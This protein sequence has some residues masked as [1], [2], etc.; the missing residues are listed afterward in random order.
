MISHHSKKYKHFYFNELETTTVE[1]IEDAIAGKYNYNVFK[2]EWITRE[3]FEQR[4]DKCAYT[5]IIWSFA[6]MQKG[7]LFAK[8]IED[9]KRSLHN[10]VVYNEWDDNAVKFLEIRKWPDHLS[11]RGRRLMS[12]SIIVRK[13][14]GQFGNRQLEQ[15]ERLE[16]LQR[17][18]R[19]E[20]LEQLQRLEQ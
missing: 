18:E 8:E 5:R 15:L 4:K 6:N 17:L 19:L 7:Y 9:Y 12:R 3:M 1:L 16:L 10:A 13:N 11:I 2:P 20:Q 14:G